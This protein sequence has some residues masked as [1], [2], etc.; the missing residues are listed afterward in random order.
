MSEKKSPRQRTYLK[1][2][3][4]A[5][6]RLHNAINGLDEAVLV[7][8]PVVDAWTVK[9]LVGHMVSWNREFRSNIAA[10]LQGEHPGFD[11]QISGEDDFS[12]ANHLWIKQKQKWTFIR[13]MAELKQDY[14]EANE[15]ISQLNPEE[16]RR[17][18][19]TPWKLAAFEK[20]DNIKKSDM[21][22]V[23]TLVT[24]HWRHMNSHI[25]QIEKWREK[26]GI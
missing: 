26:M 21:D 14:H 7:T 23:E 5:H 16:Y 17:C 10:I 25:R 9:D 13:V 24:F 11:H 20:P 12:A 3:D 18:G 1:R 22:T 15:L 6:K 19:I 8:E 4:E 2:L